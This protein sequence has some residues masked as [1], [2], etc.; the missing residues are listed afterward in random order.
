MTRE[1]KQIALMLA[2]FTLI[3]FGVHKYDTNT[4]AQIQANQD[5]IAYNTHHAQELAWTI[6]NARNVAIGKSNVRWHNEKLAWTAAATARRGSAAVETDP[7]VKKIDLDAAKVYQNVA[8]SIVPYTTTPC[9]A[10]P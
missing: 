10:K 6:C 9:G 8:D 4:Q 3:L 5:Q 1:V 2:V 7:A